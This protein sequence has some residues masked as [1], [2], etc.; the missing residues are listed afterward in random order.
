MWVI[1]QQMSF[2]SKHKEGSI[3]TLDKNMSGLQ[4]V[5]LQERHMF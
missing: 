4:F 3:W 5:R 2:L 1:L